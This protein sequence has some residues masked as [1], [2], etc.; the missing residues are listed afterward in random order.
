MEL[1]RIRLLRSLTQREVAEKA[2]IS[3]R[4]YQSYELGLRK[5]SVDVAKR[6]AIALGSTIEELFK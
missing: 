4:A 3:E 6:I 2:Q 5:P 1:K